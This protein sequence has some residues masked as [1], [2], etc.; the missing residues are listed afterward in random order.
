[1]ARVDAARRCGDDRDVVCVP[2]DAAFAGAARRLVLAV[3]SSPVVLPDEQA[4]SIAGLPADEEAP[5]LLAGA[6]RAELF[7]LVEIGDDPTWNRPRLRHGK[8]SCCRLREALARLR[9]CAGAPCWQL[10]RPST[11]TP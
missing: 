5:G 6:Q 3:R 11:R 9:T 2:P 10:Y 8:A 7:V 1:H 4:P